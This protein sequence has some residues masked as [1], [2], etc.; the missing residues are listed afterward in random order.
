MPL[1][2]QSTRT[3]HRT[4]YAGELQSIV[5]HKRGDDQ[6]QG[7]VAQYVLYDCRRSFITKAGEPLLG[8]MASSHRVYW[9]IPRIELDRV[10][11]NYI[12]AADRIYDP[13]EDITYQP[14]ST[15][16]IYVKLFGNMVKVECVR[17]R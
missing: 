9:H 5:L 14:E 11:V 1:T 3:F 7:Q 10:G 15:T 12:N 13:E 2:K 4:L 8:D 6:L 16:I 17:L